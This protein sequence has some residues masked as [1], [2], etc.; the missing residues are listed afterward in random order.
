M[1]I[2]R[3]E[4]AEL[5][6]LRTRHV[7]LIMLDGLRWQEVFGGA[8]EALINKE[9]GVTHVEAVREAYWRETPEARRAALMPF[10]WEVAVP[11]GQ[12]YGNLLEGSDAQVTN[13]WR[14]SYPGYSE[15]FC[16]YV[17]EAI[18][19]NRRVMNP[20]VTV[21][22]WL[23]GKP[24]F[25][26]RVAC[27]GTWDLYPY[28][29]NTERSGL[30]VDNG[31]G[32]LTFG[33]SS[34][35]IGLWNAV[36]AETPYRWSGSCFD[37]MLFRPALEW[38]RLNTPR[39]VFLGLGETDEWAHEG[40]YEEY[41]R[42]ARRA[43]G[44]MRELWE[45]VQASPEYRDATSFVV[46][47]DHGRG[48]DNPYKLAGLESGEQK[49]WRDHNAKVVGAQQIWVAIWG[50]DTP[51][52]GMVRG[53]ERVTQSQVAATLAALLGQDYRA[54]EPRAGEAIKGALK[55]AK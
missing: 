40:N 26:G 17:N 42:A 52:R 37:S 31:M 7:F 28:I 23:N 21:F 24:E 20:D 45:Y 36:R 9:N 53:G 6:A 44:Y 32:P 51:A 29:I 39:V 49:Q 22:E 47:C 46:L 55:S 1:S 13:P 2:S 41:L 48:G 10:L 50:P 8:D 25:E 54:A 4:A 14:V 16:G 38:V 30:P 3:E 12:I 43:D 27:F 15:T 33:K 34:E 35:V 5:P 19:D 11:R 18:R